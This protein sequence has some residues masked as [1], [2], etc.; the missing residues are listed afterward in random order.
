MNRKNLTLGLTTKIQ[1]IMKR[2]IVLLFIF[3]GYFASSQNT[4]SPYSI[5]GAGE[6][7]HK[8]FGR[9]QAMG[10]AGIALRS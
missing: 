10:G 7:Q 5:F 9:S 8:G 4:V 1:H 6:L 2:I 3:S